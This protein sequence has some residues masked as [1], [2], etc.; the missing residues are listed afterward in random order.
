MER[1]I[2]RLAA[3]KK[4]STAKA[5]DELDGIIHDVLRKLRNGDEA[6][7]PGLGKFT[8]GRKLKFSTENTNEK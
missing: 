6:V 8:P 5:K 3:Q 1:L 7:V 4:V 2:R